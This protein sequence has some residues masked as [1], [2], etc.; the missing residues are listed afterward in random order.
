MAVHTTYEAGTLTGEQHEARHLLL[1]QYL[2][3]LVSD[4]IWHT[5]KLPSRSS[6]LELMQWSAQQRVSPTEEA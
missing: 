1:H 6:V 2:D 3:E 5:G 4:F